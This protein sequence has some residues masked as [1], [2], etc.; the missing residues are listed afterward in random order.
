MM[1]QVHNRDTVAKVVT[2]IKR[3]SFVVGMQG[4][5]L[6]CSSEFGSLAAVRFP[7]HLRQ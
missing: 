5:T 1:E 6:T 4:S 7:S 3:L 2:F